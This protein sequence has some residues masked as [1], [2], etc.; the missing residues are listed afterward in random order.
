MK[1]ESNQF[2]EGGEIP[3]TY[4]CEGSDNS[5][6]L[7]WADIPAN[8]ASLVLI[9]DD[10]DAPDPMAPKMTWDHWVL[11]NIDPASNGLGENVSDNQLPVGTEVGLSS[12]NKHKYGGPCP[13]IGR[14]RYFFHLYALDI[15]LPSL[16]EATSK[17]VRD[18]MAGHVVEQAVLMGTYQK[19]GV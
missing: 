10:P 7:S 13:P 11:Y 3:S 16:E 5:P 14:H 6:P 18:A 15:I 12:W 1:I 17:A 8:A 2:Q 9:M 19:V 4:T